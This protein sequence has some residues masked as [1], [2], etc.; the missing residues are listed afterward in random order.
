M[1]AVQEIGDKAFRSGNYEQAVHDYEQIL[2]A[3]NIPE[4]DISEVD[5]CTGLEVSENG[6]DDTGTT[7]PGKAT[8]E[9]DKQR[10]RMQNQPPEHQDF[11]A[12]HFNKE[13]LVAAQGRAIQDHQLFCSWAED[14]VPYTRCSEFVVSE[15]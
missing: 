7:F 13:S 5:I 14:L 1:K 15:T 3:L 12:V 10:L 6:G 8:N 9:R 11:A 2:S 4:D